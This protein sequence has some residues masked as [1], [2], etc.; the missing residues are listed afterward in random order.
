MVPIERAVAHA[1]GVWQSAATPIARKVPSI[2]D[3]E[4]GLTPDRG[5]GGL[6]EAAFLARCAC[7][8]VLYRTKYGRTRVGPK[9]FVD[10][11]VQ[12]LSMVHGGREVQLRRH[13][14]AVQALQ[15][16]GERLLVECG[17]RLKALRA[18]ASPI[19]PSGGR[20]YSSNRQISRAP[21]VLCFYTILIS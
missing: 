20:R 9:D 3:C 8:G 18:T 10:F 17:A 16:G 21:G 2:C 4:F 7:G 1:C 15:A 11:H 6:R 13:S 14:H 5:G 12:G 19:R